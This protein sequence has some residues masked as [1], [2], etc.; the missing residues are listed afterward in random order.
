MDSSRMQKSVSEKE[1]KLK[2]SKFINEK[3]Q[4]SK[5]NKFISLE[6]INQLKQLTK[7][8]SANQIKVKKKK[9][10]SVERFTDRIIPYANF[11]KKCELISKSFKIHN[12][13][14][15]LFN[16]KLI[17]DLKEKFN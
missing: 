1:E 17:K 15:H 12:N 13:K 16:Q 4:L 8:T 5:Q 3:I 14:N 11:S 2:D 9:T 6:K 10:K 7:S